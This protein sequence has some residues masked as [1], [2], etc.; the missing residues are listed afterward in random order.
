MRRL[1]ACSALGAFAALAIA[2]ATA[3]AQTSA[4]DRETAR[5]LM[6]EGYAALDKGDRKTALERFVAADSLV[7]APTTHVAVAKAQR[8]LGL[9]LEARETALE[10]TRA[11]PAPSE[12]RAFADA[13]A[14]A[15]SLSDALADRIPS[16]RIVVRGA[17]D[18][19]VSVDGVAVPRASLVAP[20]RL[21]PGAHHVE[22]QA[23][24]LRAQADVTLGEGDGKEVALELAP[25]STAAPTS[26]PAGDAA[27]EPTTTTGAG[28]G[29]RVASW[30]GFGVGVAGIVTGTVTG[31]LAISSKSSAANGGCAG[32]RCPPSTYGSLDDAQRFGDVS[33][34]AFVVG[35]IGAAFGVTAWI[36]SRRHGGTQPPSA[37][38]SV[39][40]RWV[41]IV[42]TIE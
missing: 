8:A 28:D 3:R 35:G 29:W 16:L 36:L 4:A 33:T 42:G 13:R 21:D 30:V 40:P 15:Q 17:D 37:A 12:P 10:V 39:G 2:A 20:R 23:G 32:N 7:H 26:T 9:L 38:I 19:T 31:L 22:A 18:A 25:A 24:A 34:V 1:P 27:D 14:E 11:R 5:H 41:G 6:D